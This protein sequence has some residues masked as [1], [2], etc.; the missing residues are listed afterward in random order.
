MI[1][2]KEYS[3]P[4]VDVFEFKTED[5]LCASGEIENGASV[6]DIIMDDKYEW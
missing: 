5:I 4:E 2:K 1:M 6:E 3:K